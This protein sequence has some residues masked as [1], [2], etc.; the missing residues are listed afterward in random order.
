MQQWKA[1]SRTGKPFERIIVIN[2]AA[3]ED[4]KSNILS[5][6]SSEGVLGI[7]NING[8]GTYKVTQDDPTNESQHLALLS[9]WRGRRSGAF[10]Y[11]SEAN[12]SG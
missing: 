7:Q 8:D 4:E 5:T 12:E 11:L 3:G 10:T 1:D 6:L 9:L 2:P